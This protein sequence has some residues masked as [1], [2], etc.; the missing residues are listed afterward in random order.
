MKALEVLAG[1]VANH[2]SMTFH[3]ARSMKFWQIVTGAFLVG[4][5]LTWTL[6]FPV[7]TT[8]FR[9]TVE[10]ETPQGLKSGSSVIE[11][12]IRDVKVGFRG[13]TYGAR[14]DAVFVDLGQ[15]RHVIALLAF[16][17]TGQDQ[18]RLSRVVRAAL[19]PGQQ[20]HWT[21]ES[22]LRGK[23]DLPPD[24]IPTLVTF[25]DLNDPKTARVVPPQEFE[26]AFGPGVRFKRAW[27]ETVSVGIW[28]L[29]LLGITGEPITRGIEQKLPWWKGPGRPASDARRAWLAGQTAGPSIEP[30]ILFS[31]R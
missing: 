16:G 7:Y 29:N 19:A 12:S 10:V 18:D 28:P 22:S 17:P 26:S 4:L 11:T 2:V 15:G 25:T 1:L 14:G 21:E 13:L 8:R 20:R 6:L 9:L 3:R 23:G 24:Y 5:Y 31:T 30:E 27:I